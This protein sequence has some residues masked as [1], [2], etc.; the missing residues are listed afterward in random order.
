MADWT[1]ENLLLRLILG[2]LLAAALM[3]LLWLIER[4]T[5]N[6]GIVDVGWAAGVG[7]IAIFLAA[8]SESTNSRG[9]LAAAML[10]L[11]SLRLARHL[12]LDRVLGHAEDGRYQTLRRRWGRRAGAWFFVFFQ[13]QALLAWLF[14]LPVA[15]ATHAERPLPDGWDAVAVV[16]WL[17]AIIGESL[18]DRQLRLFRADSSHRRQTCRA[19]LWRYSRHPN[20]F[21][22]WLHWWAYVPLVYGASGWWIT[23]FMPALMLLFLFRI[24]GIPATEAQAVQSRGEDYRRYQR[25]TSAFVPWFPREEPS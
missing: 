19:G 20:Y 21:F 10:G 5:K 24:T 25:T 1:I 11:W 16:V 8:T 18:A 17:I 13:V 4:R 2:W 7:M 3:T 12:L 14:A 22:E 6:A 15:V 9:W 23:L